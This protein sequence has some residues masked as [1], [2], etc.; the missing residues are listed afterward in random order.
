MEFQNAFTAGIQPGGLTNDFEVRVFVCYL[1][2]HIG[3]PVSFSQLGEIVQTDG[4]VNYFEFAS[5]ISHLKEAKKIEASS[6]ENGDEEYTLTDTGIAT[7][8]T[9]EH[10]VPLTIREKGLAVSGA[11]FAHKRLMEENY[12]EIK[13]VPDG[14]QVTLVVSDIG[15][16]LMRLTL[17]APGPAQCESIRAAFMKNPTKAY[18]SVLALFTD[19]I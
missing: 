9:F 3:S 19:E 4:M 11:Y 14:Y 17:F 16:D 2:M 1:L 12:V 5:A 18:R 10:S 8:K 13:Q 15:S 7:A 6:L